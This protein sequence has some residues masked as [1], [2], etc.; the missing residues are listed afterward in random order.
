MP[1]ERASAYVGESSNLDIALSYETDSDFDTF[2]S[3]SVGLGTFD[4]TSPGAGIERQTTDLCGVGQWAD[5]LRGGSWG[6][7]QGS[8]TSMDVAQ[9]ACLDLASVH[10]IA[11][12]SPFELYFRARRDEEG[13]LDF[14]MYSML[15]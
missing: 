14:G 1:E 12:T 15:P 2:S 4:G 8:T 5:E 11:T 3:Y 13:A 7:W 10:A 6:P 9:D